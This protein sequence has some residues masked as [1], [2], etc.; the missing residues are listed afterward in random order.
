MKP[1]III[2]ALLFFSTL[3]GQ[4]WLQ[5][6]RL[7]IMGYN[8]GDNNPFHP[9][10]NQV[11]DGQ[12]GVTGLTVGTD[13]NVYGGTSST[14]NK[15]AYVIVFKPARNL[16]TT[17]APL[18]PKIKG[19]TKI[20]N[21]IAAGGDGY[22]YGGTS[23]YDDEV[24]TDTALLINSKYDGGRLFRFKEGKLAEIEDLGLVQA[25][26][27]IRTLVAD[28][29]RQK[30]YGLTEPS[31]Q[32][33]VYDLKTR[34]VQVRKDTDIQMKVKNQYNGLRLSSLGKAMVVGKDGRV[35]GS[36]F[37]MKF[38]CFDPAMDKLTVT[39]IEI[40]TT[41]G[42]KDR[43]G[44]SAFAMTPDGLIYGGTV[45]GGSL[46]RFDPAKGRC[47]Y[48]GKPNASSW[49]RSLVVTN[50]GTVCGI[51]GQA[52]MPGMVFK[53]ANG[54][55]DNIGWLMPQLQRTDYTWYMSDLESAVYLKQ[56][57]IVFGNAG[58]IGKIVTY[59]NN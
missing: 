40:P 20:H 52:N 1:L 54:V 38:F 3:C 5:E 2:T 35:W 57:V 31:Y 58:R 55:Y 44:V 45:V 26:E 43:D 51:T 56:G 15:T 37:G 48:L 33:F 17:V 22:V 25:R 23:V 41:P 32:F 50:D 27:G 59:Y 39:D 19:Q 4:G 34:K 49:V 12:S 47:D 8:I 10:V 42:H 30:L 18:E 16:V 24:L 21:A 7:L 6:S 46:F 14:E 36:V 29:G 9:N 11:P 13:G 28:P 53:Y